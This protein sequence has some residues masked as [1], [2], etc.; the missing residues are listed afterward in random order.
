VI[1]ENDA[2]VLNNAET[3]Q[4]YTSAYEATHSL[5]YSNQPSFDEILHR[6]KSVIDKL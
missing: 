1:S 2:F 4:A 3:R 6:I 5:Y